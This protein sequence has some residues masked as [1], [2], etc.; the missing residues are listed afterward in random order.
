[1]SSYHKGMPTINYF[2]NKKIVIN[3]KK[4]LQI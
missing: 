1:M 3:K 4:L 2:T